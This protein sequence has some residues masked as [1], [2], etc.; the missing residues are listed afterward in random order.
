MPITLVGIPT[1]IEIKMAVPGMGF[2]PIRSF[3][4][5]FL[6]PLRLPLRHPGSGVGRAPVAG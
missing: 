1:Q 4:L 3:E 5:R 2:E 6:R